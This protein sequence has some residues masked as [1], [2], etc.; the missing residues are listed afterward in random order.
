MAS[1]RAPVIN[2][3]GLQHAGM[4]SGLATMGEG[5]IPPAQVKLV[6]DAVRQAC[7]KVDGSD[8]SLVENPVA[9]KDAF[10]ADAL[11]CAAGQGGDQCLTEAQIKAIETLHA[12]YKFPFPLA[13]GLDVLRALPLCQWPAWPH[14]KTGDLK[15]SSSFQCAR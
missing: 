13:N 9:C 12:P 8:D 15:S 6:A 10:K 11:R 2:W 7:D 4:R 14:Y 1:L 3:A 5:W